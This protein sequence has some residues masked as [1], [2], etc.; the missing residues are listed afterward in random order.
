M[1][2]LKLQRDKQSTDNELVSSFRLSHNSEYIGELFQRYT[3]LVFG[4]CMKYLK[5]EE[6]SK[7]AVMEIFEKLLIDLKKHD[8]DNFKSWLYSV[9]KNHCLMKLRKD[10]SQANHVDEYGKDLRVVME[11]DE[12]LHQTAEEEQELL[13]KSLYEGIEHLKEE[14]RM[15]VELFYMQN[16]SYEEVSEITGYSM[17]QVKSYIQNGK[18]NLKIFLTEKRRSP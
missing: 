6:A 13:D 11:N 2:F 10:K 17:M 7:D 15:C 12:P 16:K 3:H 9:A 14:Q 1:S 5:E 4:V 18:R 8:V